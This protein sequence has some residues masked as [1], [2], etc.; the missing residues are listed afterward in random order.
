MRNIN[1]YWGAMRPDL[2]IFPSATFWWWFFWS[3]NVF[4]F[5]FQ[6]STKRNETKDESKSL[7][8]RLLHVG[9]FSCECICVIRKFPFYFFFHLLFFCCCCYLIEC[10]ML[11]RRLRNAQERKCIN[12]VCVYMRKYGCC[13][14][15]T[16]CTWVFGCFYLQKYIPLLILPHI[17]QMFVRLV[18]VIA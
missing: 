8:I 4:M 3:S 9:F 6:V 2:S 13:I 10:S 14:A 5:I 18:V 12:S 15:I 11:L 1:C 16:V 17:A 7:S